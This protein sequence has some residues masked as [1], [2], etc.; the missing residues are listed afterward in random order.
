MTTLI[1]MNRH[2]QI[3]LPVAFVTLLDL[4]EGRYFKAELKGNQIILTPIDPVDRVFSKEDLDRVEET[5]QN[6]KASPKPVTREWIKKIHES[7]K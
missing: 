4:G 5:F 1:K 7:D 3:N 6:E 2:R